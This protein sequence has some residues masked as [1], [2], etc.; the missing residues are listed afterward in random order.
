MDQYSP[1][2]SCIM[3]LENGGAASDKGVLIRFAGTSS[4]Y[5]AAAL[6]AAAALTKGPKAL[7]TGRMTMP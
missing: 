6:A 4:I 2:H 5:A 1:A 7:P 3:I